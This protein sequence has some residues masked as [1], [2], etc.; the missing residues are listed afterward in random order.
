MHDNGFIHPDLATRNCLVGNDGQIVIGDYGLAT[1][2]NKEDYYW[3][4]GSSLPIRWI[5]PESVE[6]TTSTVKTV[7]VCYRFFPHPLLPACC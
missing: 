6:C 7:R 3:S 5:A 1:Q 4:S 2:T